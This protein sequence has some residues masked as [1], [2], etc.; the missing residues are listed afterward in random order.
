[1]ANALDHDS[2]NG[3]TLAGVEADRDCCKESRNNLLKALS[4]ADVDPRVVGAFMTWAE[5]VSMTIA[6]LKAELGRDVT[7]QVARQKA[8]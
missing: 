6:E 4:A 7:R 3:E 2:G 5:D 8:D 1:M